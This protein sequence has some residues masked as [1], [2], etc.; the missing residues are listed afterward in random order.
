[1][2]SLALQ[3]Q[4][5]SRAAFR[6][7]LLNFS[8][9]LERGDQMDDSALIRIQADTLFT[10]D[11][12]GR[13]VRD[14]YPDG[15]PAPRLFV[16]RSLSGDLARFSETLPDPIVARLAAVLEREP[17]ARDLQAAPTVDALL[18]E[19]LE[20]HAPVTAA[21]GGPAYCFPATIAQPAGVV[22]VTAENAYLVRDTFPTLFRSF[23]AVPQCVAVVRDGAAVSVCFSSRIGPRAIEAEVETLPDFRGRGYAASLTA[24]WGLAMQA[25]GMI[26]LYCT[27]W[28][29]IASQGV[30]RRLGLHLYGADLYCV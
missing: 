12:R 6:G 26:P 9:G 25:A 4:S 11:A 3:Q 15:G 13:T 24:A 16:G 19:V 7:S 20:D 21:G 30:A 10:Y 2:L 5:P 27:S 17:P 1:M 22:P 28:E 23:A 14:N 8:M 29:N 18:R